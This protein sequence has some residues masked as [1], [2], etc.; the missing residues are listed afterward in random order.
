MMMILEIIKIN[1]HNKKVLMYITYMYH[2]WT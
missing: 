1:Y 2:S